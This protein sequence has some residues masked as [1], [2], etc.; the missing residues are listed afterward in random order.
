[1]DMSVL[2]T[3][4][5]I[6]G[7]LDTLN[8]ALDLLQGGASIMVGDEGRTKTDFFKPRDVGL[9]GQLEQLIITRID[10]LED[11]LKSL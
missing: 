9:D 4:I 1:M 3:A 5:E 7:Q 6:K 8:L 11:K 2:D 10:F